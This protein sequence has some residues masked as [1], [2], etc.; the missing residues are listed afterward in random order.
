MMG[1]RKKN[2]GRGPGNMAAVRNLNFRVVSALKPSW[3]ESSVLCSS[4]IVWRR[5]L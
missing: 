5:E 4:L 3:R 2:V 1:K